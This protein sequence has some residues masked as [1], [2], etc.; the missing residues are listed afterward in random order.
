MA[1]SS[2]SLSSSKGI[3]VE[4]PRREMR[5]GFIVGKGSAFDGEQIAEL[6]PMGAP[7][8]TAPDVEGLAMGIDRSNILEA[9]YGRESIMAGFFATW[10]NYQVMVCVESVVCRPLLDKM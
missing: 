10:G 2:T 4:A 7:M 3:G 9:Q 1:I 5:R 8:W 6:D